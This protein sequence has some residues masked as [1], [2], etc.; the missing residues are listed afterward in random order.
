VSLF[1]KIFVIINFL[2]AILI[3]VIVLVLY[4]RQVQYK[5]QAMAWE[6]YYNLESK[7][8]A[9]ARKVFEDTNQQWSNRNLILTEHVLH[10]S[11]EVKKRG[12][13]IDT[14]KTDNA[15][16]TAD[17]NKYSGLFTESEAALAARNQKIKE[18]K[19]VLNKMQEAVTLAL[20]QMRIWRQLAEED[21]NRVSSLEFQLHDVMED[22]A[23]V[24]Q[25]RDHQQ[26]VL[27]RLYKQGVDISRIV[28]GKDTNLV[29]QTPVDTKVL[30]VDPTVGRVVLAAGEDHRVTR[31]MYFTIYRGKK[32][33]GKVMVVS[34]WPDQSG[35]RILPSYGSG[36]DI[37]E[38]DLAS[39][40]LAT[41]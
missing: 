36:E 40:K 29:S 22:K 41:P 30:L 14:A 38:G 35:A 7:K 11:N 37:I 21:R 13:D 18:Y 6:Y 27:N 15:I 33:I 32:Y 10:L 16:L 26:W 3:L 17:K 2:M 31:G 19:E 28:Y 12:A 9:E 24:E 39:S 1:G 4:S 34:V 8:H 20:G 5:D 23:R 25:D